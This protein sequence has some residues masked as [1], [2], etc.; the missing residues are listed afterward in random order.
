MTKQSGNELC[1]LSISEAQRLFREKKLSPVELLQAQIERAEHVEPLINALSQKRFE[2]AMEEA[3]AAEAL[4]FRTPDQARPL[5]GIPTVLKNEHAMTGFR[6]TQ[7]SLLCGEEEDRENSPLTQ[8]LLDAGAVI[9][10]QT[11]VPEFYLATFTRSIRH[12]VTRNPWNPAVTCGGSSGGSAAALA[13]GIA[14]LSSVSDIG[15]SIRI[16]SSYCGV[17]GIKPSYGRVPEGSFSYAI[18]TCNHNGAMARTVADCAR[19]LNV[20]NGPH[21]ADP[22]TVK[23]RLV[24]PDS[25]Q[26]IRGMR[27]AVSYDLGF[28]DVQP[29]VLRNTQAVAAV[30]RDLGATVDEVALDWNE[31]VGDVFTYKLGFELGVPLAKA[32]KDS[33]DRVNDYV[34]CFADLMAGITPEQYLSS[35]D[36]V[37]EMYQSMQTIL[38]SYDALI[39][40]TLAAADTPAEGTSNSH[41][42]LL[43]KAMTYPF[44]LLSRYPVL[45]VPS[46]FADNGVP[47]GVQIVGPTFEEETVFRIG[48]ALEGVM[49]WNK[50][51]PEL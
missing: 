46:G 19:M 16:P 15:G 2:E 8:R 13:S 22:T 24:L 3:R 1:Y 45:S 43:R 7:G 36:V 5:E 44:N 20:I 47:T 4:Y 11:N 41:D 39:C 26:P 21:P 49:N 48:A 28:F 29:D 34:R 12:G 18:N 40:P 27:I 51:H 6:T 50:R 37:G 9:H 31:R 17:V 35:T 10:A 14:T 42:E 30:L 25:F 32:I 38:G 23:P 33:R